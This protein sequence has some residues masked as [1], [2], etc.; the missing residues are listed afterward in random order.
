MASPNTFGDQQF[1]TLV[2]RNS[3]PRPTSLAGPSVQNAATEKDA[4]QVRDA[5]LVPE[6]KD[7]LIES[8][9][10]AL[11]V[12][13]FAA[14]CVFGAWAPLSYKATLDGNSGNQDAQNAVVNA[15]V[16]LKDQARE[17]AS[18]QSVA[19]SRQRIAL[20]DMNSRMVA[21]GQLWL[22]DFCLNYGTA[23][24]SLRVPKK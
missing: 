10:W 17:A 22:Y 6:Q 23:S 11:K 12:L 18:Q 2:Q 9:E 15:A 8:L 16:S 21:V 1:D 19:A 5:I 20:D 14:A 24:A 4:D 13:G 3:V 7:K